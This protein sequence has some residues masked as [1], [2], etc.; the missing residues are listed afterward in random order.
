MRTILVLLSILQASCAHAPTHPLIRAARDGNT[1]EIVRLISEGTD[2]NVRGGVN[3]WTALMHA[4]HKNRPESVLALLDHGADPNARGESGNTA[5]I[6][7][8]GYGYTGLVETLL[9]R[10]ADPR[11]ETAD[12]VSALSAAV[13]GVN[14]IDR[15]TLGSCQA[16]TVRALLKHTPGLRLSDTLRNKIAKLAG[17]EETRD[18]LAKPQA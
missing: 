10:G 1:A 4:I 13:F 6:M 12:G 17:C 16:E 2:P 18:L 14:D 3:G 9:A 8:A 15:F 7:A 11:L 5:L